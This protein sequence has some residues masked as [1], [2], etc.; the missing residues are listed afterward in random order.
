M[1]N[2]AEKLRFWV[3][4]VIIGMDLCPWAKPLHEKGALHFEIS[5]IASPERAHAVFLQELELLLVTPGRES[6]LLAFPRWVIPF[7]LFH[8]VVQTLEEELEHIELDHVIQ[9]VSFHPQFVFGDTPPDSRAHWVNR[10]PFPVI[11]FLRSEDV[12]QATKQNL[13]LAQNLSRRNEAK[14]AK[15]TTTQLHKLFQC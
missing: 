9:L 2:D 3:E 12:A 4:K 5:R 6:T 7:P 1:K 14:L 11:H 13:T 10:S 15:L 8:S